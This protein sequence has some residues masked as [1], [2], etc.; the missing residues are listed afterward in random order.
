[1]KTQTNPKYLLETTFEKSSLTCQSDSRITSMTTTKVQLPKKVQNKLDKAITIFKASCDNTIDVREL[2]EDTS[3]II[4]NT[5]S[6]RIKAIRIMGGLVQE[7]KAK[8]VSLLSQAA[9]AKGKNCDEILE[10]ADSL[11]EICFHVWYTMVDLVYNLETP[12]NPL[13]DCPVPIIDEMES[14]APSEA[15]IADSYIRVMKRDVPD[16]GAHSYVSKC[17]V[18]YASPE[19]ESLYLNLIDKYEK[20][21]PSKPDLSIYIKGLRDGLEDFREWLGDERVIKVDLDNLSLI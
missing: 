13:L 2:D 8:Y 9:L 21:I 14:F 11:K 18:A 3:Q 10:E 4:F 19:F 7:Y 17:L 6:N 12:K 20:L 1:M 16:P 5:G 15:F